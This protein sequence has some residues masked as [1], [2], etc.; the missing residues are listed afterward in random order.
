MSDK[1][2]TCHLPR[3]PHP[4]VTLTLCKYH[5]ARLLARLPVATAREPVRRAA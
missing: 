1:P 4:R 2:E 3:C 5:A